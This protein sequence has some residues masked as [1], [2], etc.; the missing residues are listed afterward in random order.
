MFTEMPDAVAQVRSTDS[1]AV[2]LGPGVPGGFLHALGERDDFEQLEVFGALL[3]D[4]Y[5]LFMRKGV[6]YRS[7]FFGPGER[8]LRDAGAASVM[9][10]GSPIGSGRGVANPAAIRMVIDR[11]KLAEQGGSPDYPVI[12]DA[13]V[14]T[15]SDAAVAFELGVDAVLMNTAVAGARN[16]VLMAGAMKKAVEAG[17]EAFLAG[18]VGFLDIARIVERILEQMPRAALDSLAV[19]AAVDAEARR[20]AATAVQGLAAR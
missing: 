5:Q 7:G 14:G 17:R 9:P 3:P 13:G 4:L 6:R 18:R 20:R 10:A 1:L 16:P 15:A 8:F 2:P 19:V 11:L 12:V